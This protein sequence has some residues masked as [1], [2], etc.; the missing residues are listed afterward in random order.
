MFQLAG[1]MSTVC[2]FLSIFA[3]SNIDTQSTQPARDYQGIRFPRKRN[4]N[5]GEILQ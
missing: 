5:K 2:S 3:E 1:S 4:K